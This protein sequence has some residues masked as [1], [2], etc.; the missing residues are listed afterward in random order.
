MW[1]RS[2]CLNVAKLASS[3]LA[4]LLLLTALAACVRPPDDVLQVGLA[5]APTTLDPRYATDA[6]SWRLCRLLF[7]A[8]AGF[9]ARFMP[10]PA[11]MTWQQ[12]GPR[13]YRFTLAGEH[14]FSDGARLTTADVA[15]TY[16]AVLDRAL[17]S[18]HRASLANL[19]RIDVLDAERLEF[20]LH[21]P[22]PLFPGLLVIGVMPAAAAGLPATTGPSL[23]SGPFVL[24]APPSPKRYALRRLHDG[25]RLNFVVV[26]NE[27]TRVLKLARGEL[28]LVQGGLAPENIAWLARQPGITV[29]RQAGSTFSYLGF[30]LASGPTQ[31]RAVRE[32]IALAID[33]AA[34]VDHVLRGQARLAAAILVPEHW[35]GT[36][37]LQ[38]LV[39]DPAR[40]R[41]QLLA[42]GY[43]PGAPLRLSYKTSSDALRLRIAA[44]LQAQL[45]A[46]GV[47]LEIQSYDWGTFYADIKAGRFALYGLS[48]VGLQLPDIFRYAFRSDS[49]PPGGANRGRYASAAADALIDA[50]QA[51]PALA[52]RAAR[53]RELQELLARDLPYVP[54][55]YEDFMIV[56]RTR[57]VGYHTNASGDFDGLA[58][59]TLRTPP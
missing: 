43:H 50:A 58:T 20:L 32:A 18:P 17:A 39:H 28:D 5:S 52:A 56:S 44:I 2:P 14:R 27:T 48:W 19:V 26:E 59:V 51:S 40:A 31:V 46:V 49:V 8:P 55:W 11:L 13:R 34:I 1:N 38:P 9:D 7:E 53:Y 15:A 37:S 10:V 47:E 41:A 4:A 30:N 35:A 45:A 29:S 54:L 42:L 3:R 12:I 23:G 16:R 22:D 21:E 33:R 25:Q 57:L 36:S 24:A 6:T